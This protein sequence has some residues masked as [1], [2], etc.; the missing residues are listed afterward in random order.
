MPVGEKKSVK[1][2]EDK[3]PLYKAQLSM[4]AFLVKLMFRC[5]PCKHVKLRLKCLDPLMYSSVPNC[6]I[7]LCMKKTWKRLILYWKF[8]HLQIQVKHI[9]FCCLGDRTHIL[10]RWHPF[11]ISPRQ[12]KIMF[13]RRKDGK[14]K[15]KYII[16]QNQ[17][18][19]NNNEVENSCILEDN[20]M[21]S[22][23]VM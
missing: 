20:C 16:I 22:F 17:S 3:V 7:N 8:L 14:Y 6:L 9:W 12:Q 19:K 1:T 2:I 13:W 4:N 23:V 10:C 18:F 11:S 21:S 15:D 5:F